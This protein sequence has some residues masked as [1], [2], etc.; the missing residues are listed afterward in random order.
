MA[1]LIHYDLEARAKLL[2]GVDQ[3]ANAVR[4]SLGPKVRKVIIE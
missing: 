1:N 2:S 4:V 3:L